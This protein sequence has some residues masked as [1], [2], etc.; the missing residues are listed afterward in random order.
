MAKL[1]HEIELRFLDGFKADQFT[2][3]C[4][5]I[6]RGYGRGSRDVIS[7]WVRDLLAGKTIQVYRPEGIF[8]YV[9]AADSAEGLLRLAEA[10]TVTGIINLG[11]GR[12]RRVQDVVDVL[13]RH[14]PDMRAETIDIDIP[15][16]ASQA[17]MTAYQR[18][19]GWLPEHDLEAGIAEI[20]AYERAHVEQRARSARLGAVLVTSASRKIPLVR[21]VMDAARRID[22]AARVVAGDVSEHAL[23]RHVADGFW[24]MPRTVPSEL[25]AIIAGCKA[26]GITVV[27]PTRDGE[28]GFWAEHRDRLTA[29]GI[30]VIVSPAAS[31]NLCLDKLAFAERGAALGLPVIAAALRPEDVGA[32][33][34]VVKERYGAGSR[35]IGLGLQRDAAIAHATTLEAPIYQPFVRGREI[36]IDAWLDRNHR[37]KGLVPRTR[38]LVVNGESQVTT[39]F[40]EPTVE[41][42]ATAILERLELSGPVVMQ[43]MLDDSGGLFVIECNARFGGAS[44]IGIAAGL[45]VFYWSLREALGDDVRNLPFN[46]LPGELR[47]VRVP[48]D[49]IIHGPDL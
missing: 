36:S 47:Q 14:F 44:T 38:N 11:S 3:V 6:Y 21:A 43:A 22:S 4:A 33:P 46:R 29:E 41:A 19:V 32:G 28:L 24:V 18:A 48:Q 31:V 1:A 26:R 39:T 5:R 10:E 20:V 25:E 16:E 35:N 8:D 15:Y 17:D 9:Y 23:A 40:R 34:Y 7:R 12:G 13:A 30:S 42:A 45:D 49:L 2:T 27:V 37:L